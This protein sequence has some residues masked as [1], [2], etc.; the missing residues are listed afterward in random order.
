MH[1]IIKRTTGQIS[2]T[3]LKGE[4]PEISSNLHLPLV[5]NIH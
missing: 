4:L 5:F 2:I 1:K 3:Q